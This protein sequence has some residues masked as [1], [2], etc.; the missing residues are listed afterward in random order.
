MQVE[1]M[2]GAAWLRLQLQVAIGRIVVVLVVVVLAAAT[3]FLEGMHHLLVLCRQLCD[4]IICGL[5]LGIVC[6]LDVGDTLCDG[7]NAVII[8]HGVA[9]LM[10]PIWCIASCCFVCLGEMQF[11][12][13]PGV[14]LLVKS[15]P[16]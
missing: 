13:T 9:C 3:P 2:L 14:I 1:C 8:L 7:S 6:Q 11:K 12:F 5:L 15:L 4:G 16:F 10:V